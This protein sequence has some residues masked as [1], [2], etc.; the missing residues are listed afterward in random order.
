MVEVERLRAGINI[1]KR[2]G[3][4]PIRILRD[5][6]H[7][8]FSVY[9]I[10]DWRFLHRVSQVFPRSSYAFLP[11]PM[12]FAGLFGQR[13]HVCCIG[14]SAKAEEVEDGTDTHYAAWFV[15]FAALR[16]TDLTIIFL[17]TYSGG[18]PSHY[19]FYRADITRC[20]LFLPC[21]RPSRR[22]IPFK[23]SLRFRFA[24]RS[25]YSCGSDS[26]AKPDSFDL[27]TFHLRWTVFA[28]RFDLR[29]VSSLGNV[30]TDGK[31]EEK[32]RLDIDADRFVI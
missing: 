32:K 22:S 10:K 6:P 14:G 1:R 27:R 17:C 5:R 24:I 21:S 13:L 25:L 30:S 8:I 15:Y 28:D 31:E 23:E 7:P 29:V 20:V 16:V 11:W 2:D 9:D 12:V 19:T 18:I 26:N 3:V 4:F